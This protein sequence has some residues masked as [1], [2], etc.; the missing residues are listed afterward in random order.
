M[1]INTKKSRWWSVSWRILNHLSAPV[2]L[3]ASS[4]HFP[5]FITADIVIFQYLIWILYCYLGYFVLCARRWVVRA[6]IGLFSILESGGFIVYLQ[7]LVSLD[8]LEALSRSCL[9]IS[10]DRSPKQRHNSSSV[11]SSFT[12]R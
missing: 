9:T 7:W 5:S 4:W 11:N 3:A 8:P 12:C 10:K 1:T 6:P 2:R